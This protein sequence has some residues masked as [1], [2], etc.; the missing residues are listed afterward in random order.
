MGSH[1]EGDDAGDDYYDRGKSSRELIG[2]TNSSVLT[3]T[4]V[5]AGNGLKSLTD[6]ESDGED[7]EIY[8]GYYAHACYCRI[9]VCTG[10]EVKEDSR[11]TVKALP[12]KARKS[13]GDNVADM[14]EI[15]V[16]LA[17]G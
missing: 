4:I 2:F 5:E 17:D 9:S 8:S 12:Y 6:T 3:R 14:G 13:R 11:D 10:D 15:D 7:K 1:K 16:D